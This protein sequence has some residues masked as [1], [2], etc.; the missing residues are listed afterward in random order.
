MNLHALTEKLALKGLD[1]LLTETCTIMAA[2]ESSGH[3]GGKLTYGAG[4][5]SR[6]CAARNETDELLAAG[7]VAQF[8]RIRLFLPRGTAID[9]KSRVEFGGSSWEVEGVYTDPTQSELLM[10]ARLQRRFA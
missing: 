1:Q 7:S 10:V 2:S 8:E 9:H 5:S 3:F 4:S 6:C